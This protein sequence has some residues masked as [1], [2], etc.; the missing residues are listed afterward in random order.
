MGREQRRLHHT[1]RPD[2]QCVRF[3]VQ[4]CPLPTWHR[5]MCRGDSCQARAH[6]SPEAEEDHEARSQPHSGP[7]Q[8]RT[9]GGIATSQTRETVAADHEQHVEQRVRK[10]R[11]SARGRERRSRQA[12][13]ESGGESRRTNSRQQSTA[14]CRQ[15]SRPNGR[16]EHVQKNRKNN[17]QQQGRA[18]GARGSRRAIDLGRRDD[19]MGES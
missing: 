7:R 2:N 3:S 18:H 10:T 13:P 14:N 12:L 5:A 1:R 15:K 9:M 6:C 11:G 16:D 17:T 8:E 19:L 4:R